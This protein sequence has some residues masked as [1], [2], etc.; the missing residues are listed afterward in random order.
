MTLY[1]LDKD[2]SGLTRRQ[3]EVLHLVRQGHSQSEIADEMGLTRQ[4]VSQIIKDLRRHDVEM[5]NE[6]G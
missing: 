2:E 5:T 3:R 4:R 6:R 1:T